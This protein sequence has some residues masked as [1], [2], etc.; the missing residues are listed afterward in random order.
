MESAVDTSRV[1]SIMLAEL[2]STMSQ[3]LGRLSA[4]EDWIN[5]QE[6]YYDTSTDLTPAAVQVASLPREHQL[7]GSTPTPITREF[8]NIND[9]L[10]KLEKRLD[11]DNDSS[12]NTEFKHIRE[13]LL[14]L[15][16]K[17]DSNSNSYNSSKLL[18]RLAKL[19]QRFDSE[20][21]SN[22]SNSAVASS[23]ELV[24][25]TELDARFTARMQ[26]LQ[27]QLICIKKHSVDQVKQSAKTHQRMEQQLQSISG[28]NSQT[29]QDQQF[30]L[31]SLITTVCSNI[32][33]SKFEQLELLVRSR[34]IT[35]RTSNY[36]QYNAIVDILAGDSV[37][38]DKFCQLENIVDS[39]SQSQDVR[40]Q[41]VLKSMELQRTLI[42]DL[43]SKLNNIDLKSKE[44][45]TLVDEVAK[46]SD[47]TLR[48]TLNSS[49]VIVKTMQ[50]EHDVYRQEIQARLLAELE[51][52]KE[53]IADEAIKSLQTK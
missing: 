38:R 46:V 4:I 2:T 29:V 26:A 30:E 34:C 53:T 41:E 44:L 20:K 27:T 40:N 16:Q 47:P 18:E 19:E 11:T 51:K 7:G 12:D 37:S 48:Q 35:T 31:H 15:E 9:R 52:M 22:N 32:A 17:I 50:R 42:R 1:D 10:A 39:L 13:R 25:L 36:D 6:H 14:T 8:R 33:F 28:S 49:Q 45:Q 5:M 24:D 23:Q 21:H 43:Y 3:I